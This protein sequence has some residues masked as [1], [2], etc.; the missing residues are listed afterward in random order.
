M[1][2]TPKRMQGVQKRELTPDQWDA[3][4]AQYLQEKKFAEAATKRVN[5]QKATV[6][7]Y[8][9]EHGEPDEKGSLY[10]DVDGVDGVGSVKYE[11]R[12]SQVM[13]RVKVEAWLKKKGL[14]EEYTEEVRVIDADK[15]AAAAYETGTPVTERIYQSFF[16]DSE[17]WALRTVK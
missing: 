12:V 1:A 7:A 5:D 13:D 15:L 11:R 3:F 17:T 6:V 16:V 8:L 4:V 2:T 10:V 14:W 9:Q